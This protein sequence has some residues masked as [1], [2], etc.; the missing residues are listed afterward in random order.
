MNR[1]LAL[2]LVALGL[3]ACHRVSAD[4]TTFH[5]FSEPPK[6]KSFTMLPYRSQ[7]G[8]LEW[9]SYANLVAQQL[10]KNG[11]V[12]FDQG[13]IADYGV[14]IN[15]AVDAGHTSSYSSP[16]VGPVSYI[17]SAN[18]RTTPI[19]GVIGTTPVQSTVYG[20]TV[21]VTMY[22]ARATREQKKPVDVISTLYFAL[23]GE[24]ELRWIS[25]RISALPTDTSWQALARNALRD[26]L[27]LQIQ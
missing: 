21:R 25:E 24:L 13:A 7:A 20:S 22:D 1:L 15:Y 5:N 11:L 2:L 12:Q 18:G 19:Y 27:T 26:D 14:F 6:G 17:T 10:E 9:R 8:S 23:G 4:V 16:I 3:A